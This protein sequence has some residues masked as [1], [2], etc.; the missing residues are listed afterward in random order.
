MKH[1]LFIIFHFL[2][3]NISFSQKI[4][5]QKI[6]CKDYDTYSYI[7]NTIAAKLTEK[8]IDIVKLCNTD[9]QPNHWGYEEVDFIRGIDTRGIL[10]PQKLKV[11]ATYLQDVGYTHL[12]IP[13]ENKGIFRICTDA[14]SLYN[15]NDIWWCKFHLYNLQNL[16]FQE[17]R[18]TIST[19]GKTELTLEEC[20]NIN[21]VI[22]EVVDFSK[23]KKKN[24]K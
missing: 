16:K 15:S 6:D 1:I 17:I 9:L 14:V 11:S 10:D 20:S 21:N 18:L 7:N 12:L 19:S 23:G 5:F 4:A 13:I 2:I 22:N 24:K 3:I 8:G